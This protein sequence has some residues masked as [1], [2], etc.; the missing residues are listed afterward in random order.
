MRTGAEEEGVKA[1]PV[2]LATRAC[3]PRAFHLADAHRALGLRRIHGRAAEFRTEQSGRREAHVAHGLGVET[4]AVLVRE[5][6]VVR[7][8]EC[9]IRTRVR[10]ALVSVARDNG[11]VHRFHAPAAFH[12]FHSEPVEQ[13]LV[14]RRLPLRAE[15]ILSL[16]D[17]FSKILEPYAVHDHP[18]GERVSA[19]RDPAR[20]I[21]ARG[22][23][24]F[25]LESGQHC[26]RAFR[27]D[28]RRSREVALDE[29]PSLAL[30]RQVAHDERGHLVREVALDFREPVVHALELRIVEAELEAVKLPHLRGLPFLRGN[31]DDLHD[32]RAHLFPRLQCEGFFPGIE[33]REAGWHQRRELLFEIGLLGIQFR[34]VPLRVRHVHGRGLRAAVPVLLLIVEEGEEPK[35]FLLRD[36]IEFVIVALAAADGQSEP[37]RASRGDAIKD[38]INAELLGVN[39]ALA[40]HLRVAMEP[41]GNELR[42]RR[43]FNEIAGELFDREAVERHV[44]IHRADDPVAIRPDRAR[45]INAV[46]IA[47]RISRLVEPPAS[48][49][50]AVVRRFQQPL[51]EIFVSARIRVIHERIHFAHGRR[52]AGEIE[53]HAPD[54]RL[55]R[56]GW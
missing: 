6:A 16:D 48:P 10:A 25:V 19:I 24:G 26:R 14:H 41:G 29:E 28:I 8:F 12:E 27:H 52:Q 55:A 32:L 4:Q 50:F 38:R 46:S 21:E 36:R 44:R 37:H 22:L 3:R 40:V 49:A 7:V 34:V 17:P 20:E 56:G 2:P 54:E 1:A 42:R 9:E 15:I 30:R 45:R 39:A 13:R 11:A 47:V 5:Q 43:F 53:R 33:F 18:C 35:V 51:D 31:G 23:A